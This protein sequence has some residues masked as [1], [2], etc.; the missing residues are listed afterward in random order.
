[1]CCVYIVYGAVFA[2]FYMWCRTMFARIDTK[3]EIFRIDFVWPNKK[4]GWLWVRILSTLRRHI[5]KYTSRIEIINKRNKFNVQINGLWLYVKR[6]TSFFWQQ[7]NGKVN[8][9][10]CWC[11]IGIVWNY[12]FIYFYNGNI[13]RNNESIN[14]SERKTKCCQKML[15]QQRNWQQ[16]LILIWC[17]HLGHLT[18]WWFDLCN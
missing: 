3:C 1:M 13:L 8:G 7:W 14:A 9:A 18:I 17:F 12:W 15:W 2:F 16:K 10:D 5:K 4:D 6:K 11:T